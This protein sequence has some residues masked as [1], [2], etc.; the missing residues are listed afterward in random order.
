MAL[1]V[2]PFVLGF[3][4]VPPAF[5]M[6]VGVAVLA[7]VATTELDAYAAVAVPGPVEPGTSI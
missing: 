4:G 1:L 2:A 3:D 5:Y 7:F 6:T